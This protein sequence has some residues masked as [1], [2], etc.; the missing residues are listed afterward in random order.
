MACEWYVNLRKSIEKRFHDWNIWNDHWA[1]MFSIPEFFLL[2]YLFFVT[3]YKYHIFR[4]ECL[5]TS[6]FKSFS[7]RISVSSMWLLFQTII[8]F[9]SGK[10]KESTIFSTTLNNIPFL[11]YF[12]FFCCCCIYTH[13]WLECVSVEKVNIHFNIYDECL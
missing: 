11:I 2:F 3:Q 5:F 7:F 8:C 9:F 10:K 6:I 1:K 4:N 13:K 12:I